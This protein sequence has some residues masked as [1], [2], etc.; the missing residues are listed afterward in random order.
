MEAKEIRSPQLMDAS[1]L[2]REEHV[3][4]IPDHLESEYFWNHF[5]LSDS[6]VFCLTIGADKV[7]SIE[8]TTP[9]T[10]GGCQNA[11]GSLYTKGERIRLEPPDGFDDLRGVTVSALDETGEVIWT[12]SIP[13]NEDNRGF[14][15]LTQDG[16][17]ITNLYE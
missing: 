16:W 5:D 3:T 1:M 12:A 10:S 11:D 15:R 7:K 8:V 2:M 6:K 14:T 13:D 17:T 4:D 9:H